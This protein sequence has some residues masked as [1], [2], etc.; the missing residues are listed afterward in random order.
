MLESLRAAASS[1]VSPQSSILTDPSG[2]AS[3]NAADAVR[4]PGSHFSN[5]HS[6]FLSSCV[7]CR[8]PHRNLCNETDSDSCRE[9]SRLSCESASWPCH[10]DFIALVSIRLARPPLFRPARFIVHAPFVSPLRTDRHLTIL[11]RSCRS[12]AGTARSAIIEPAHSR[13]ASGANVCGCDRRRGLCSVDTAACAGQRTPWLQNSIP[14][15]AAELAMLGA[16]RSCGPS[17]SCSGRRLPRGR[18]RGGTRLLPRPCNALASS[19][20][21]R[22]LDSHE[23]E[24]STHGHTDAG[25]KTWIGV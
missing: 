17:R 25:E 1:S 20:Q 7:L 19:N 9:R 11:S 13:V 3:S 6:A 2:S 14:A 22:L 15:A 24:F 23:Q 5:I 18:S 4:W 10:V 8:A 12:R 21:Q 16:E